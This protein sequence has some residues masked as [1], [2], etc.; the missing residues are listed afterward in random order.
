MQR[1]ILSVIFVSSG[2]FALSPVAA[3][4]VE[5]PQDHIAVLGVGEIEAEPD[6]ATLRI[7]VS[8]K[9]SDLPSAKQLAD[10]RYS[11]V[12]AVL[13]QA[14]IEAQN[15]KATQVIAQPQYEWR[16]N[17]RVYTGEMVLRR[18]SI[19]V[20]DL[21][22]VSPL[23]E[24]LV[25][26]DVSTIDGMDTGFQNRA[27][28]MQQALAAAADDAKSKAQFLAQRLGRNLGSAFQITESNAQPVLQNYAPEMAR[29]AVLAQDSAPPEM[30]G[31]QKIEA[32][33]N[34]LFNLL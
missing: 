25:E 33:L 17:K 20:N 23:M 32:R 19:T 13:E 26:N 9:T 15:I 16:S 7:S 27:E 2:L 30:F 28:L 31:S 29:S 10:Q 34:V 6:Q 3:H 14:E 22:K 8:A 18:L 11:K 24:A 4:E 12:L 21:A 1:I 5:V